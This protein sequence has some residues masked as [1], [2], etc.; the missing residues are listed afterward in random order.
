MRVEPYTPNHDGIETPAYAYANYFLA[1]KVAQN[2]RK[3]LLTAVS[4]H[5]KTKLYTHNQTP[6]MPHV[7][8][9][10][11]I[12]F[13]DNMPYVFKCSKINLNITLRSIKKRN[14]AQMYGYHGCR[15]LSYD[16]L[17]GRPA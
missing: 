12:D 4:E 14:S 5:F 3:A 9:Q 13:Y 7:I 15:W 11:P 17:P 6:D 2:E 1:R 8:N 16:E 10:G